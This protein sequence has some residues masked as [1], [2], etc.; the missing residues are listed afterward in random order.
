MYL[1][2]ETTDSYTPDEPVCQYWLNATDSRHPIDSP[3]ADR[4]HERKLAELAKQASRTLRLE[5][6]CWEDYF[7]GY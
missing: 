6:T 1:S 7:A 5:I 2:D 4:Q 3:D